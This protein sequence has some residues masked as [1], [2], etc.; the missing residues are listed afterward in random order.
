MVRIFRNNQKS[1]SKPLFSVW[2]QVQ[3]TDKEMRRKNQRCWFWAQKTHSSHIEHTGIS[4]ENPKLSLLLNVYC[5][6][7]ISE[8]SNE[9]MSSRA[10]SEK[11][12]EQILG[13]VQKYWFWAPK[14]VYFGQNKIFSR[15]SLRQF[16]LFI[17][18]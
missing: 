15:K 4:F 3:Q 7:I 17:K 14:M 8:K 18:L 9:Q 10:I 12:N 11:S 2:H 1:Y 16:L 13:N 6:G 5:K